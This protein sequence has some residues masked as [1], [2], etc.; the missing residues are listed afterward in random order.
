MVR[1]MEPSKAVQAFLPRRWRLLLLLL[2]AVSGNPPQCPESQ[3]R[4]ACSGTSSPSAFVAQLTNAA[5]YDWSERPPCENRSLIGPT[6]VEVQLRLTQL[7][8]VDTKSGHIGINGY[9]RTWWRDP[10]LAYNGTANGGCTDAFRIPKSL[11]EKL[12]LPDLYVDNL[13][14]QEV[15]GQESLLEVY[16]SGD[17]WRS[18][19]V[20]WT[21][22][23]SFLMGK[24]PFDEH[25]MKVLLASY[26][27]D[28][29]QLR[30][31]PR[32]GQVGPG[33]SGAG[34]VA[35]PMN[36]TTWYFDDETEP[37]VSGFATKGEVMV[38]FGSWDYVQLSWKIRRKPKFYIAQVVIP[39][40]LF[41]LVS[42]IQFFVDAGAAPARAALA[43]IPVLIM[44]TMG[45]SLYNSIPEASE[46]MWL[47][48]FVMTCMFMSVFAALQFAGVQFLRIQERNRASKLQGLIKSRAVAEKL[49]ATALKKGVTLMTL[50]E[51]FEPQERLLEEDEI[52][53][54]KEDA[55]Q[56]LLSLER[57]RASSK[58]L[59]SGRR[60][61]S[62]VQES[63]FA[64]PDELTPTISGERKSADEVLLQMQGDT[65]NVVSPSSSATT[66]GV[67]AVAEDDLGSPGDGAAGLACRPSSKSRDS[68][69]LVLLRSQAAKDAN[70]TEADM[71]FLHY[72]VELFKQ[73]DK[74]HS[75]HVNAEEVRLMLRYFNI[76]KNREAVLKVMAMF[77]RDMNQPTPSNQDEDIMLRFSQFTTLLIRFEDYVLR[78]HV[79]VGKWPLARLKAYFQDRP[80]SE[81]LDCVARYAFPALI[82]MHFFVFFMLIPHY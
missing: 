31:V 38:K 25:V 33:L 76:Y 39:V 4:R 57:M 2:G 82:M 59:S 20:L 42:Y 75:N 67:V 49:I 43:V 47:D 8:M 55:L 7:N 51:E 9:L 61:Q 5:V 18:Q 48:D 6:V 1:R 16:P 72:V 17:I 41:L 34:L 35:A 40:V 63:P 22:K 30:L 77:L 74:D 73:Y 14:H 27:Q 24:V 13:V 71:M 64:A 12:W 53:A 11:A 56:E 81:C 3:P 19:Q 52:A 45:N 36:H 66:A 69:Q 44:R 78:D 65:P 80:P 32:G 21:V 70:V 10:R 68:Q 79:A 46:F 26:S 29:S 37:G 62:Q 23:A 58:T 15:D 50:M 28:N 54:L 60:A